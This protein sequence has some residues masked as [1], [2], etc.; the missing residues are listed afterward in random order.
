MNINYN[1]KKTKRKKNIK[2]IK[3]SIYTK[4]VYKSSVENFH[5]VITPVKTR[6][7]VKKQS[8]VRPQKPPF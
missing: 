8:V 2:K 7:K 6:S 1:L 5:H 4:N 3:Y